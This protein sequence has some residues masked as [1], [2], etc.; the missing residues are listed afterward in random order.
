MCCKRVGHLKSYLHHASTA[1]AVHDVRT[2]IRRISNDTSICRLFLN[3]VNCT[4]HV[5]RAFQIGFW[6]YCQFYKRAR[7]RCADDC[8]DAFSFD[9][10][11]S[12]SPPVAWSTGVGFRTGEPFDTYPAL[13]TWRPVTFDVL[14]FFFSLSVHWF[15]N[16]VHRLTLQKLRLTFVIGPCSIN[17]QPSS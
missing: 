8:S 6:L 9:V 15:E 7:V 16:G 1:A 17:E 2:A 14:F 4:T 3:A 11:R 5:S 13:S 12:A 10:S